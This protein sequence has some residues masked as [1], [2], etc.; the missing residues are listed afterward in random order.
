MIGRVLFDEF[1]VN[2][3]WPLASSVAVVLLLLLVAPIVACNRTE[4]PTQASDERARRPV[5]LLLSAGVRLRLLVR[6]VDLGH[7]L[8]V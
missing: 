3:D 5:F 6:A 4:P 2:R 1:F 8:F 7:H